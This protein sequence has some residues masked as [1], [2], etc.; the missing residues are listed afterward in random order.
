MFDW[1]GDG[2]HDNHPTARA[3]FGVFYGA[4]Q[5]IYVREPWN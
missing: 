1:D 4:R 2:N 3:S 5:I